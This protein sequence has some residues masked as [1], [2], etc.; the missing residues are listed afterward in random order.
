MRG[1][2][3]RG[4][5]GGGEG[6]GLRRVRGVTDPAFVL[7]AWAVLGGVWFGFGGGWVGGWGGGLGV[8]VGWVGRVGGGGWGGGVPSLCA[9]ERFSRVTSWLCCAAFVFQFLPLFLFFFVERVL[10]W[11]SLP[12]RQVLD[13][14]SSPDAVISLSATLKARH[15]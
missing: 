12:A 10:V 11:R 1:G 5:G 9:R 13:F 2:G 4:G 14:G 3:C 8:G 7:R 15:E 6:R